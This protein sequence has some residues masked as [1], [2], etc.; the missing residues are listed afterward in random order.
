MAGLLVMA[1]TRQ[2]TKFFACELSLCLYD[3]HRIPWLVWM[4]W[5]RQ[6]WRSARPTATSW[7]QI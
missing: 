6:L 1:D 2:R 4:H 7:L 5:M 3:C